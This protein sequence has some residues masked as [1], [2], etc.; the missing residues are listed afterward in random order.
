MIC[1]G[2]Y[3]GDRVHV[4]KKREQDKRGEGENCVKSISYYKFVEHKMLV[5]QADLA[6]KDLA[7]CLFIA[8][9]FIIM[10]IRS[11]FSQKEERA[12]S[13]QSRSNCFCTV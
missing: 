11:T 6:I 13:S 9:N 1:E 5:L 3:S 10:Y 8:M 2:K 7:K 4:Q 12:E